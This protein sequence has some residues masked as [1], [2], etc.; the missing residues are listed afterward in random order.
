M[1]SL[2]CSL[3]SLAAANSF[4]S[5]L[6]SSTIP[7]I[8]FFISLSTVS[9]FFSTSLLRFLSS[10]LFGDLSVLELFLNGF[11]PSSDILLSSLSL[12][13]LSA[14]SAC[15]LFLARCLLL[16][17]S[18]SLVFVYVCYR[19]TFSTSAR[20]RCQTRNPNFF[21]TCIVMGLG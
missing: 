18:H 7:A 12:L 20:Y 17:T 16:I 2:S 19:Y 6:L 9:I 14:I 4:L 11:R 13:L 3:S 15:P 8:S 5:T 10:P 1:S 21:F